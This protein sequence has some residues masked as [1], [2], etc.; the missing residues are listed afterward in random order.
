F[1]RFLPKNIQP[2]M[3]TV[4]CVACPRRS[5]QT[6]TLP[7]NEERRREWLLRLNLLDEEFMELS[8]KCEQLHQENRRARLCHAHFHNSK[9][10]DYPIDRRIL[11]DQPPTLF[12][13]DHDQEIPSSST[14]VEKLPEDLPENL[15]RELAVLKALK[16]APPTSSARHP[17]D[18]GSS[19]L[20]SAHP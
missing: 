20:H 4:Q 1:F 6:R 13:Q 8:R 18:A 10:D 12:E 9:E 19:S 17:S 15:R 3:A 11:G 16:V 5:T 14:R 7:A 2:S